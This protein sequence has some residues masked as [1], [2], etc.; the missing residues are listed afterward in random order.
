MEY[1]REAIRKI[2]AKRP[3]HAYIPQNCYFWEKSLFRNAVNICVFACLGLL[4]WK[5]QRL[6]LLVFTVLSAYFQNP[7]NTSVFEEV[8]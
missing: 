4:Q 5:I 7:V 3:W 6:K 1:A 8:V 2:H